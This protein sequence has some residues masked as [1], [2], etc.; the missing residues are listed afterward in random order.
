MG[1]LLLLSRAQ[2][3]VEAQG[4]GGLVDWSTLRARKDLPAS[5]RKQVERVAP[6]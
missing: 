4:D 5:V 2:D 1:A 3:V 6:N